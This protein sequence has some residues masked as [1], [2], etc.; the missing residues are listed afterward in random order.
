MFVQLWPLIIHSVLVYVLAH[1]MVDQW[2]ACSILDLLAET[3]EEYHARCYIMFFCCSDCLQGSSLENRRI[4]EIGSHH[5]G[6][7]KGI[8]T[9]QPKQFSHFY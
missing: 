9:L 8:I 4:F 5:S 6:I 7:I 3:K 2:S 1:I